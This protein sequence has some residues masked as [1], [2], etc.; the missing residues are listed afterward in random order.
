LTTA[1]RLAPVPWIIII[2]WLHAVM[3]IATAMAAVVS[4]VRR[5]I[6]F[7]IRWAF[8]IVVSECLR[9]GDR[10]G[11]IRRVATGPGSR[12]ERSGQSS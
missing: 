2:A 5:I 3:P 6:D 12:I 9:G 4:T 10:R 8:L 11:V 1:G 7:S